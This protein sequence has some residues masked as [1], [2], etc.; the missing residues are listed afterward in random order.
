[1]RKTPEIAPLGDRGILVN[2]GNN[3][4]EETLKEV[5]FFKQNLEKY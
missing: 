4:D 3:I 5:L 1:M 2:F